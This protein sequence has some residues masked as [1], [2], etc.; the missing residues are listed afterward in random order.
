M[1]TEIT[2]GP[3][4]VHLGIWK[5]LTLPEGSFS[6]ECAMTD[7]VQN[8]KLNAALNKVRILRAKVCIVVW[9]VSRYVSF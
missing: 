9:I 3:V 2:E 5:I 7:K 1:T 4:F 6:V 8:R